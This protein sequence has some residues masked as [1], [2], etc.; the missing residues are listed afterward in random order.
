[1]LERINVFRRAI[2][3]SKEIPWQKRLEVHIHF[4]VVIVAV[5]V[6][7][8]SGEQGQVSVVPITR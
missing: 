5:V 4:V 6:F 3:I 2:S 1:M 8:V 7:V